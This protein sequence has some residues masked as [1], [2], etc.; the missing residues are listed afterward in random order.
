MLCR[1]YF[2]YG[3]SIIPIKIKTEYHR[4]EDVDEYET[5]IEI[6]APAGTKLIEV[7]KDEAFGFKGSIYSLKLL[8]SDKRPQNLFEWLYSLLILHFKFNLQSRRY[9]FFG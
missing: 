9:C 2:I 5:T 6:T 4:Y 7:S 1:S 3:L 8:M